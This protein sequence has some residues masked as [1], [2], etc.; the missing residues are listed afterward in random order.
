MSESTATGDVDATKP[1]DP[2]AHG[3]P[4]LSELA[5]EAGST[6]G[7]GAASGA[8]T[9]PT[10]AAAGPGESSGGGREAVDSFGARP[11]PASRIVTALREH[12]GIFTGVLIGVVVTAVVLGRAWRRR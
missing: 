9:Q 8:E 10:E 4:R 3:G 5:E 6:P 2:D 11:G 12:P 1:T 7:A